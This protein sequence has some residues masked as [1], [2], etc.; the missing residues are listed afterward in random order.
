MRELLALYPKAV[1]LALDLHVHYTLHVRLRS[2]G[3]DSV[4]QTLLHSMHT[5]QAL[6]DKDTLRIKHSY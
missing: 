5:T 3:K 2:E 4:R 6:D 1:V